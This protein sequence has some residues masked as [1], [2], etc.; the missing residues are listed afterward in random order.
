M[1]AQ[2]IRPARFEGA[3]SAFRLRPRRDGATDVLRRIARRVRLL[4]QELAEIDGELAALVSHTAPDLLAECGV[5]VVCAQLL[6]SSVYPR[7]MASEA[8]L[9][10]LG[11]TNPL[12]ASSGKHCRNLKPLRRKTVA[13]IAFATGSP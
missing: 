11:G 12:D 6:V 3:T 7:R 4:D 8:S 1:M 13:G 9:A 10:A 5:G 2:A